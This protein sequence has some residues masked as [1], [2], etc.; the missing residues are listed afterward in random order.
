MAKKIS[1]DL[2]LSEEDSFAVGLDEVATFHAIP[3]WIKRATGSHFLKL[4][5]VSGRLV[6]TSSSVIGYNTSGTKA[7]LNRIGAS[8]AK[9]GAK[10]ASYGKKLLL[11]SLIHI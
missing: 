10:A 7:V 8:L 4:L 2:A 11:L 9:Y 1:D 6:A 3:T 5:Q